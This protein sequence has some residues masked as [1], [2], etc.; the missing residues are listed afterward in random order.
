MTQPGYDAFADEYAQRFPDP[1]Q[2][3]FERHAVA[4]FAEQVH[5]ANAPGVVVD[6]GCGIGHV[7]ADL[8]RRGLRTLGCD[9]SPGMLHFAREAHPEQTFVDDDA[10]LTLI[11][12][13]IS[14]I[15]A[16][17]SLIHIDPAGVE[18][19]LHAWAARLP[20][21]APVLIATQSSDEP[22][23]ALE[24]DHAVAPAWRWHPDELHRVLDACGFVENW[25]LVSRPGGIHR[26][27]S[28]H[29]LAHRR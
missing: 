15:L 27:P 17:F 18:A 2:A 14:A 7:T 24:F 8:Y 6:V 25:R 12:E 22:G 9:P 19:V 23:S 28:V 3:P 11:T 20:R 1:Y 16:R 10:T 21:E 4:I 29:L 13:P 5:Q 26:F